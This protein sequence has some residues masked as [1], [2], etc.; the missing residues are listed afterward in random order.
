M[1]EQRCSFQLTWLEDTSFSDR[2]SNIVDDETEKMAGNTRPVVFT[3]QIIMTS[4]TGCLLRLGR[5]GGNVS[6]PFLLTGMN[7]SI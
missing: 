4:G 2:Q 5:E 1:V 7:A 6:V 3:V